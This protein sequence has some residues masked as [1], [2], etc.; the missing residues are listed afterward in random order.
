MG[1]CDEVVVEEIS[2]QRVTIFRKDKDECR[3][4]TIVIRGSTNTF[5]DDA[6]RTIQDAINTVKCLIRDPRAL[7]GAGAFEIVFSIIS[8]IRSIWQQRS[9]TTQRQSQD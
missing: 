9:R 4:G 1:R 7:P 8:Q 5:M 2:S 6:E 3:I